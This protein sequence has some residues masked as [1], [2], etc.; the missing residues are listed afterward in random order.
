MT[1]T[2]F[3]IQTISN[4]CN[5]TV[6]LGM[7]VIRLPTG[8]IAARLASVKGVTCYVSAADPDATAAIT[9]AK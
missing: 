4:P 1:L 9:N 6:T 3:P 5:V 7:Y 8:S 2:Y